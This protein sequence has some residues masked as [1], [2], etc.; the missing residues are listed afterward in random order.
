[1]GKSDEAFD[2]F[3]RLNYPC[4][5]NFNPA[6]HYILTLAIVPGKEEE[7]RRKTN[8]ICDTFTESPQ[9]RHIDSEIDLRLRESELADHIVVSDTYASSLWVQV[10]NL[11]WRSWIAQFRDAM[12]F[13]VRIGQSL[14]IGLVLGLVYLQLDVDQKGVQNINGAIYLLILNVTF[15]N[16]FAVLTSFPEEMGIVMRELGTGLY[17]VDI[18]YI[19]KIVTEVRAKVLACYCY[20]QRVLWYVIS[21][22]TGDTTLALSLTSPVLVP[23]LLFG[24]VFLNGDDTPVYF[25]WLEGVSWFKYS[26]ELMMVNQWEKEEYIE[27]EN[28]TI[29]P[30]RTQKEICQALTC[31]FTSGADVLEYNSMDADDVGSDYAALCGIMFVFYL[32]AF[33]ALSI[34]ARR[35]KE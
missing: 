14:A 7:C 30:N 22:I 2:F 29:S 31:Q 24:G 21:V 1:M 6:D 18:Y 3:N 28:K 23:F 12:L 32:F 10:K 16:V 34:R 4:P 13:W 8:A 17:R 26:N 33:I 11:F 9:A 5:R 15:T 35:S 20:R 19:A 25:V 27:C